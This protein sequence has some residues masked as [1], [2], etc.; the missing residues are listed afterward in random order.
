M[1]ARFFA[2]AIGLGLDLGLV[3]GLLAYL[4]GRTILGIARALVHIIADLHV[5]CLLA[6]VLERF[7][8]RHVDELDQVLRAG[9]VARFGQGARRGACQ[10]SILSAAG[11]SHGARGRLDPRRCTLLIKVAH[12]HGLAQLLDGCWVEL[13]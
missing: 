7:L 9:A 1:V 2:R 11:A 3:G 13:G 12:R 4:R 6:L 8:L 5:F 10:V